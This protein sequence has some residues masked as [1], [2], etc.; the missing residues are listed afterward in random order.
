MEGLVTVTACVATVDPVD[1]LRRAAIA[2]SR[3]RAL[4]GGATSNGAESDQAGAGSHAGSAYLNFRLEVRRRGGRSRD[5]LERSE[6]GMEFESLRCMR[7][8]P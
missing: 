8:S 7:S 3:L 4:G 1:A 6:D 2:G 5:A